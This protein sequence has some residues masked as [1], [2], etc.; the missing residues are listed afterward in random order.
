MK[1][2]KLSSNTLTKEELVKIKG[3]NK[4]SDFFSSLS[5]FKHHSKKTKFKKGNS[6]GFGGKSGGGA[7]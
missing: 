5:L 1:L 7:W 3:G 6:G 2:N 4:Q